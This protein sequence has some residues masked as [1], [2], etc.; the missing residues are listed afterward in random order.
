VELDYRRVE[1]V[2]SEGFPVIYGD[3]GQ[4]IVLEAATIHRA[5]LLINTVPAVVVSRSIVDLIRRTRPSLKVI[6]RA[7]SIDEMR[8]LFES[9]VAEVVQPEFEAGLEMARQALDFL[10]VPPADVDMHLDALRAEIFSPF[11]RHKN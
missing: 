4:E 9:G 6:A 2:R 10:E 5:R 11:K 8:M 1:S 3:A 7:G